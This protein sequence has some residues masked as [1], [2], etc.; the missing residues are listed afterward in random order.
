MPSNKLGS[1]AK[2]LIAGMSE[3]EA[4]RH[5][6]LLVR[7]TAPVAEELEAA[8][9]RL[10]GQVRTRAGDVW[11]L[12]MPARQLE[13]LSELESVIYVEAAEPMGPEVTSFKTGE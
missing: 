4:D 8:I 3:A 9:Q 7:V 13:G 1:A 2:Q 5:V 12:S 6:N 10:G 11:T